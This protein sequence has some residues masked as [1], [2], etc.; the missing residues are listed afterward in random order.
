MRSWLDFNYS[1]NTSNNEV[2]TMSKDLKQEFVAK[3]T[4]AAM[5][6]PFFQ[7]GLLILSDF[8]TKQF[9]LNCF[10]NESYETQIAEIKSTTEDNTSIIRCFELCECGLTIPFRLIL[11]I[12]GKE[13]AG[14]FLTTREEYYENYRFEYYRRRKIHISF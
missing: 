5:Y 4:N 12:M 7:G 3:A 10:T 6:Y 8:T 9:V 1:M 11:R 13:K 14:R 2:Y